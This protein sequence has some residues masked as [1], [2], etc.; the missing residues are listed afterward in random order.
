MISL[1]VGALRNATATT[2]LFSLFGIAVGCALGAILAFTVEMLMASVGIR[3][4]VAEGRRSATQTDVSETGEPQH[5]GGIGGD[6][7]QPSDGA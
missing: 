5:E 4:E 2:V 7:S 6:P 1:G 3:S